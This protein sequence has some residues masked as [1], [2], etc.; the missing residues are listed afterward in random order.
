M[1]TLTIFAA[2]SSVLYS[3]AYFK[4]FQYGYVAV[5]SYFHTFFIDRSFSTAINSI[6]CTSVD[7]LKLEDFVHLIAIL[8]YLL[9]YV[10]IGKLRSI[11]IK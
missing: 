1:F 8:R 9:D 3:I 10:S 7:S 11:L 6:I 5:H 2:Y 4:E